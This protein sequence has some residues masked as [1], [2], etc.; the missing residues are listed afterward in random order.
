MAKKVK[1]N[2]IKKKEIYST[3]ELAEVLDVHQRTIQA[4]VKEG[5]M[6]LEDSK[7]MLFLGADV[8]EFLKNKNKARKHNLLKNQFYCLKCKKAVYSKNNEVLLVKTGNVTGKNQTPEIHVVGSCCNCNNY[9]FRFSN[10]T[11][12]DELMKAFVVSNKEEFKANY[13]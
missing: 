9:I 7:P 5:L 11:K 2:K 13:K 1:R 4:W 12:I 8:N 3:Q 10:M 6:P